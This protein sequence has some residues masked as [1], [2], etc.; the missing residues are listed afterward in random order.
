MS[1]P[2][3]RGSPRKPPAARD[4][5]NADQ[6]AKVKQVAG[7]SFGKESGCARGLV[8]RVDERLL[9]RI[10]LLPLTEVKFNEKDLYQFGV[11]TSRYL[12]EMENNSLYIP[13]TEIQ[14][15]NKSAGPL[16]L[17]AH[18]D[19]LAAGRSSVLKLPSQVIRQKL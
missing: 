1:D 7:W 12:Q 14:T 3:H 9:K 17:L 4:T 2:W 13:S 19:A 8:G 18:D 6:G 10:A 16:Q 15:M 11:T 5:T